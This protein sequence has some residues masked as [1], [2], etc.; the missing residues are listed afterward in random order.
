MNWSGSALVCLL[1][2]AMSVASVSKAGVWVTQPDLGVSGDYNSNPVLLNVPDTAQTAAALLLDAPTTYSANDFKLSLIPSFRFGTTRGY[3]SIDSDFEHLTSKAELDSE[4]NVFSASIGAARD[5]SLYHDYLSDGVTGVRRDTG[6][7]DLNW[8][9]LLTEHIDFNTDLTS[10]RVTYGAPVGGAPTL[11]NYKYTSLSPTLAWDATERS[12]LTASVSGG[13]YNSLDGATESR[14]L[15]PQLG[16]IGKLNEIWSLSA[17]AGYSRAIDQVSE[18]LT[19]YFLTPTGVQSVLVPLNEKSSQDGSVF[20]FNLGR[21][22]E[23]LSMNFAASRQLV[24][25]GF[26]YLTRQ[27]IYEITASYQYTERWSLSGDLRLVQYQIPTLGQNASS[28]LSTYYGSVS[29]AWQ[30]TEHLTLTMSIARAVEKFA[31]PAISVDANSVSIQLVR[32][33]NQ[34]TL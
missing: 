33:F 31:T 4:R 10:Q 5:S 2:A 14:S 21:K 27:E 7:V 9:R 12:K 8:D 20:S 15:N 28:D 17:T 24:P 25:S 29:A 16:Y 11:T 18:T 30:W 23:L 3:D 26:A 6:T 32:K 19:E 13:L 34:M 1:G 22:G